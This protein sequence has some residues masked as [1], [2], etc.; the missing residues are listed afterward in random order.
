M[1]LSL[2]TF[3][4]YLAEKLAEERRTKVIGGSSHVILLLG[5]TAT[6]SDTDYRE[7]AQIIS[8]FKQQNPG[9][10]LLHDNTVLVSIKTV[11]IQYIVTNE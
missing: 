4:S 8:T 9:K 11:L 1:K 3:S 6:I 10:A 5:Y 7:S 2:A